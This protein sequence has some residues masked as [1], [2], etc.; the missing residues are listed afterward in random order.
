M[1]GSDPQFPSDKAALV[2][3]WIILHREDLMANWK[4]LV[5]V[6]KSG[7]TMADS[8]FPRALFLSRKTLSFGAALLRAVIRTT[9]QPTNRSCAELSHLA[10]RLEKTRLRGPQMFGWS[11]DPL[12]GWKLAV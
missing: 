2:K 11:V 4:L 9:D 7:M 3:A 1:L 5:N 10:L 8:K 6:P 12:F